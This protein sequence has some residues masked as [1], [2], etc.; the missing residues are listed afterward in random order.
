MTTY[1]NLESK[2][3]STTVCEGVPTKL[4]DAVPATMAVGRNGGVV[5][6]ATRIP[7]IVTRRPT[8]FA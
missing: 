6:Q 3:E 1:N 2:N 7:N 4:T 5:T 8:A